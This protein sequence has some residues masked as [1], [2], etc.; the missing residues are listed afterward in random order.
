MPEP[1]STNTTIIGAD[2]HI[3]GEMSFDHT[4]RIL[5]T[6]EGSITAKGELQIAEGATCKASVD[7][8]K[9]MV[10]GTVDGNISARERVELTAKARIKGDLVA[11]R[12]VVAE[13]ASFIGHVTVGQD[14]GKGVRPAAAHAHDSGLGMT[15]GK[16]PGPVVVKTDLREGAGRR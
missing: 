9:I 14:A 4:A 2:T 12:L 15:D 6:F 10:D 16:S 1:S 8:G 7:A 3:K 5:G 11:P 13:G